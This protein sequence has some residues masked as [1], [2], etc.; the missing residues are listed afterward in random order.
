MPEILVQQNS[1][2]MADDK[3]KKDFRDR[4]RVSAD[5]DYEIDYLVKKHGISRD[6]V[7][8]AIKAVG[9]NREKIEAYLKKNEN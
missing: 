3:T 5:E 6:Q 8:E 2:I 9:S 1:S 7:R 4:Q